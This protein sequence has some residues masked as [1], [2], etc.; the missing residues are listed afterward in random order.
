MELYEL[1]LRL[2]S[3]VA[4]QRVLIFQYFRLGLANTFSGVG[5]SLFGLTIASLTLFTKRLFFKF[6]IE[7]LTM[8][9]GTI[10]IL[11]SACQVLADARALV[12]CVCRVARVC[13]VR[14]DCT[15]QP[16]RV[17]TGLLCP[18]S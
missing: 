17:A 13:C 18:V 1:D 6:D 2:D 15:L 8:M 3:L 12:V 7:E 11:S 9:L 16:A 10:E 14:C 4:N 5:G